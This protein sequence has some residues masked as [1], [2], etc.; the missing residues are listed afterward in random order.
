MSAHQPGP[1]GPK[2]SHCANF[3]QPSRRFPPDAALRPRP[4][5]RRAPHRACCPAD[6]PDGRLGSAWSPRRGGARGFVHDGRPR[7]PAMMRTRM[8]A[9]WRRPR[10]FG[11]GGVGVLTGAMFAVL[12]TEAK[13][14]R[15]TVGEPDGEPPTADGMYGDLPGEPITFRDDRRLHR[16]RL[17]VEDPMQTP[18]ALLASGW[19]PSPRCRY[20]W[21]MSPSPA[22]S[23]LTWSVRSPSP[24]GTNSTWR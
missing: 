4:R 21:S 13:M 15:R 18:G 9:G 23:P 3:S 16:R 22:P 11:G 8:A 10:P 19:P 1:D 14:A 2:S 17:G 5:P 6:E 7:C 12:Y 20:D 24:C